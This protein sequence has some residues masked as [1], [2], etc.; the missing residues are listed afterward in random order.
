ML[1]RGRLIGIGIRRAVRLSRAWLLGIGLSGFRLGLIRLGV[2]RG[3]RAG[4]RA[5][6]G[7]ERDGAGRGGQ[8]EAVGLVRLD[9]LH[10]APARFLVGAEGGG[11]GQRLDVRLGL[12]GHGLPAFGRHRQFL[13]VEQ[14]GAERRLVLV[15]DLEEIRVGEGVAGAEL[16]EPQHDR[17]RPAVGI[18][19]QRLVADHR[20]LDRGRRRGRRRSGG[21][22]GKRRHCGQD[23][24]GPN[25]LPDPHPAG[26]PQ[27]HHTFPLM[28]TGI[29]GR[30]WMVILNQRRLRDNSSTAG[31]G[32]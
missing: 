26:N 12:D 25:R 13:P 6:T 11:D 27:H 10:G 14:G 9:G 4:T 2:R 20:Q 8:D 3:V 5:V 30:E 16:V 15:D 7:D 1:C 22:G 28:R 29:A 19:V 17:R 24:S 23:G 21:A 31:W 32:G 18:G